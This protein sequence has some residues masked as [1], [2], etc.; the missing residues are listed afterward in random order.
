MFSDHRYHNP[1]FI[2][3]GDLYD[4]PNQPAHRGIAHLPFQPARR[5]YARPSQTETFDGDTLQWTVGLCVL[6][7]NTKY[8]TS[9]CMIEAIETDHAGTVHLMLRMLAINDE[10]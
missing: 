7:N 2:E 6:T 1:L 5:I 3:R 9:W 4:H 8:Q 10:R